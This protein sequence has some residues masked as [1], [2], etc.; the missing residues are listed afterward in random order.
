MARLLNKFKEVFGSGIKQPSLTDQPADAPAIVLMLP[1]ELKVQVRARAATCPYALWFTI[2]LV[3]W[4]TPATNIPIPM[5]DAP[6]HVHRTLARPPSLLLLP[7]AVPD[8]FSLG[9]PRLKHVALGVQS[10]QR[11]F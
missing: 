11:T 8:A 5:L 6:A 1:T 7:H 2:A 9:C 4:C 3:L 10:F